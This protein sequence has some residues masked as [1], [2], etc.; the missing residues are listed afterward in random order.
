MDKKQF[1]GRRQL[2]SALAAAPLSLLLQ[3][4]ATG[5]TQVQVYKSPTC[6][7]CGMWVEHMRA[8]GFAVTTRDVA[9]LDP[10]RTKLGVPQ[11]LLSCHTAVVDGY[12]IEGHVPAA[13]ITRML[14]ERPKIAGLAVPGM[15]PGS[16]GMEGARRDPYEVL[17]F[18]R[19]GAT[20]V[21]ARYR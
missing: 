14:R 9:D 18:E 7:C 3:G 13:E 8:A 5:A 10:V 17:A 15:V 4:R 2:L 21:Y 6:G 1:I 11:N 20:K 12:L 19:G 16:P